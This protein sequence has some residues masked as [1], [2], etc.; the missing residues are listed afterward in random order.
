MEN[1]N[2]LYEN[3]WEDQIIILA[4]QDDIDLNRYLY[5]DLF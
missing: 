5:M 2:F 1:R 3:Y 4:D